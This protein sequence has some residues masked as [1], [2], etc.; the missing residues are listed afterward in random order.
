MRKDTFPGGTHVTEN[1]HDTEKP[2]VMGPNPARAYSPLKQ[3]LGSATTPTVSVGD[4]VKIGQKIGDSDSYVTAPIHASISGKVIAIEEM[5]ELKELGNCIVIENDFNDE[6]DNYLGKL[7]SKKP[8]E[9][10]K[11][12]LRQLIRE[13]GIVGLGGATFPTHVKLDVKTR[14]IEY[15]ILNGGE[16]E[17]YLTADH[18]VMLEKGEK[19]IKGLKYIMKAVGSSKGIIAIEDNKLDAVQYLK[20]LIQDENIKVQVLQAKYPQGSEKQMIYACT[21]R[22]VPSGKLPLDIGV[23]VNNVAT[24]I[25]IAEAVEEKKVLTSRVVTVAGSGFDYTAN[26]LVKIGT[27]I[28]ELI[29]YHGGYKDKISKIVIGG[30]MMG[31]AYFTDHMPVTKGTSGILALTEKE[32]KVSKVRNCVRCARCVD[33]C[34][35]SLEPTTLVQLIKADRV[36]EALALGL[37]DCMEC[38]CCTYEC[39][40]SIPLVQNL[41]DGKQKARL[42]QG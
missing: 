28:R 30:P 34:P 29:E 9:M 26:Y 14:E 37:M 25:A 17:P 10:T 38:G 31:K 8:E 6:S 42:K 7:F 23:V 22:K 12:E 1:K 5:A 11:D 33:V 24:A 35:M 21:K 32:T 18:R 15:V 20:N 39:P 4:L 2:I 19:V 16:C 13:A 3:H 36:D 27:S 41:R 40:A